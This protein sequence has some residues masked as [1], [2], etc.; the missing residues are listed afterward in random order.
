VVLYYH[1][2]GCGHY[3]NATK[4][5]GLCSVHI[6]LLFRGENGTNIFRPYSRPNPFR[7]IQICPYPSPDIQYLIPYPYPN[8]Q[9][10]YLWCR[11]PIL[12]YPTLLVLSVFES[13]S[14]QKYENKC[15]ISDIRLYPI[16]FS[17]LLLLFS[18]L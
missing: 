18:T 14:G 3:H 11:C 17:S 9:I 16:R 7:G 10:V 6:S 15:N 5:C 1:I 4:I 12:S 2:L 13:E 8:T